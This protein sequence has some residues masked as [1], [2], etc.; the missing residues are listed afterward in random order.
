MASASIPEGEV[1]PQMQIQNT[2]QAPV[3]TMI[4][5]TKPVYAIF[6]GR[7]SGKDDLDHV[8]SVGRGIILKKGCEKIHNFH[9]GAY[10]D[11]AGDLK[12]TP[13]RRKVP[14]DWEGAC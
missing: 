2:T 13:T 11:E 9:P 4:G 7:K 1:S 8:F 10:R 14:C 12:D 3:T 6:S 5:I